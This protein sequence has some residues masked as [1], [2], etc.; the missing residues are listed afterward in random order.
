MPQQDPYETQ[1]AIAL[2]RQSL[3]YS[4]WYDK[5]K[6]VMRKIMRTQYIS[7]MNATAGSFTINPRLQRWF[8]LLSVNFPEASSLNTIYSAFMLKHY[9][10]FKGT[11]SEQV[12]P[13]IKQTLQLH[14][15]VAM[16]FRKTA[17]N[18]HYEFNVRHLT[19]VFQGLLTARV[20]TIKEPDNLIR[21]WVHECERIYGDRLVS[22][23]DLQ[24]YRTLVGDMCKKAFPRF[25]LTKYFAQ[26][27]P[28]PLVFAYFVESLDEK[29]YDQFPTPERLSEQ[30]N[31]ALREYNELNAVMDLVLFEDCMKHACKISRIL[32]AAGG[33]A[34]LV[35]VGGMGKQSLSRLSCFIC[36][37]TNTGIVI[38]SSYSVNDFKVDL[39]TM[40]QKAGVKDEGMMFL[41]TEGQIKTEGF[42]VFLND[43]LS[44]GEIADLFVPE[45]VDG[46][47][48]NLSPACKSD[49]INPTPN[50]VWAYFISRVKKNLHMSLCMSPSDVFRN[51]AR[52]FPAIINCTV[53][54]WFHPWP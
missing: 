23:A 12:A 15:E 24:N 46:I 53:I 5:Q 49:G 4:H 38:S 29:V 20:E 10:K 3:D 44:S 39:Q 7:S 28:E 50:N 19:N 48:T 51:R 30:L 22:P 47:I 31:L 1:T 34:L 9:V 37:Y 26:P 52:K 11:I 36:S 21:M 6:L 32:T 33:H 43:L 14:N 42:L 35:G 25:N 8:W 16:K 54:D 13:V 40:F 17:A 41:F 18:F 45:D 27:T 2:V